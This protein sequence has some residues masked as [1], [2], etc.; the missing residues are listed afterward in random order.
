MA[1]K[2]NWQ[3]LID[4][5]SKYNIIFLN[6]PNTDLTAPIYQVN[7]GKMWQFQCHCGG[8]F[9]TRLSNFFTDKIKGCGCMSGSVS[10]KTWDDV[11]VICEISNLRFINVPD[12]LNETIYDT[13]TPGIWQFQ[14]AC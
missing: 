1:S 14:C 2:Y 4:I 7:N 13:N 9:S 10:Q 12:N 8:I 11:L 6:C 5:C 3:N